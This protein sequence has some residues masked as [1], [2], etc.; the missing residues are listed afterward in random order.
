MDGPQR[1]FCLFVC[2]FQGQDQMW[3][4]GPTLFP[5]LDVITVTAEFPGVMSFL[6]VYTKHFRSR[7]QREILLNPCLVYHVTSRR[8]N[9]VKNLFFIPLQLWTRSCVRR[10]AMK[11][12]RRTSRRTGIQKKKSLKDFQI[13][14]A[15]ANVKIQAHSLTTR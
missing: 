7:D 8:R 13:T 4:L 6:Y 1:Y 2:L 9:T 11:M 14:L 10:T 15:L 12:M 5:L 3:G